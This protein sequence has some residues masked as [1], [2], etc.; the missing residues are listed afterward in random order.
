MVWLVLV[1]TARTDPAWVLMYS[2]LGA[3]GMICYAQKSIRG[4]TVAASP[5][6]Q[7]LRQLISGFFSGYVEMFATAR[8]NKD[9]ASDKKDKGM[10][11]PAARAAVAAQAN[12]RGSGPLPWLS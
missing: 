4:S 9:L 12:D 3:H 5:P 10:S 2:S 8:K 11:P 6:I 7:L 1:S